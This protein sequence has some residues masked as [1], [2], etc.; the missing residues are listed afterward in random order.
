MKA[1]KKTIIGIIL[2]IIAVGCLVGGIF[3]LRYSLQGKDKSGAVVTGNP[4]DESLNQE[5]VNNPNGADNAN[6]TSDS[7]N[8]TSDNTE[9]DSTADGENEEVVE[10]IDR[11]VN[12]YRDYFLQNEDMAAWIYIPDTVIDYPVMYTPGDENYYLNRDFNKNS[13]AN[14]CLILDTDSSMDPL[15]TNLIIHGHNMGSG[16]MFGTLTKYE[17]ASYCNEHKYIYLYGKDYEH[18]YEVIAV[19]RSKVFYKTDVTFKYYKFFNATT[20]EE[21]DDFY[22]NIMAISVYE[23]DLTAEFGDKFLTLSTCA[24][25]VENGRFVVVAKE[26]DPGEYYLPVDMPVEEEAIASDER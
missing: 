26:I 18:I 20:Q 19:F 4:T 25:H 5:S 13:N 22:N 2:G 16:A 21:F 14:G 8:N 24:Y 3:L 1:D 10:E 6:N 17:N 9:D 15:S 11:V 12:P 23:T 7:I